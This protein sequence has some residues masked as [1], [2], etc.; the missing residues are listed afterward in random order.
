MARQ[1]FD[2]SGA[3]DTVIATL[4]LCAANGVDRRLAAELANMTAGIVI[5]KIGTV[6][7][8]QEELLAE[9]GAAAAASLHGGRQSE[10]P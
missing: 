1:V 6:P 7:V 9:L 4:A 2:V 8:T 5:G 3:G 10:R